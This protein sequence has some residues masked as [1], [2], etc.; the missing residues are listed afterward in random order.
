MN[1]EKY[2]AELKSLLAEKGENEKDI[3][4]AAKYADNLI[5]LK[6]PVIF[7]KN[8]FAALIGI[9]L[10]ELTAILSYLEENYYRRVEIE[11]KDGGTRELLIPAMKLRLIQQWILKNILYSIHISDHA[12]GFRKGHSIV[13]N[14]KPHLGK[15]CLV[16]MDL[17]DFFPSINQKQI[18]QIFYYYGYT[19][20]VSYMLS[21]LCTYEG[22]VPQ[23]APTSPYLSNIVCLKL[24]KR[25]SKLSEQYEAD[26]TR[27]AD[28]MTFS[29]NRCLKNIILPVTEIVED[30]GFL[31]N[32]NKT[33]IQMAHQ[34]QEVTG[35]NVSGQKLTVR[36]KYKK[37]MFQELYYC[38]KYGPTNHLKHIGCNKR[39]YKDHMYGKA[40]YIYM[41]EPD[42]GKEI[43]KQLNEI[44]WEK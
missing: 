7:D 43:L 12:T 5:S 11:K 3:L 16:N 36:K 15:K 32:V 24:D 18:F 6:L 13:T 31:V 26:Y 28:D 30:E 4:A 23:G 9:K 19:I 42:V 22:Y 17:K 37:K 39:F 29:G 14:A 35:V 1:K 20:S 44:N 38:K 25:L 8:H 34:R 21:R 33:R 41:V 10:V 2:I 27:Y 40:F